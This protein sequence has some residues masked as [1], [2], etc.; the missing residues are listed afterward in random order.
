MVAAILGDRLFGHD[1][2]SFW[3]SMTA[4]I[5]AFVPVPF[6]FA[7]FFLFFFHVMTMLPRDDENTMP[8]KNATIIKTWIAL[9][10]LSKNNIK[11][12]QLYWRSDGGLFKKTFTISTRTASVILIC[13]E[14]AKKC[15]EPKTE[16][17]LRKPISYDLMKHHWGTMLWVIQ[18]HLPI[19]LLCLTEEPNS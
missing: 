8:G 19:H 17:A 15:F 1:D 2:I 12:Q 3:N 5:L 11:T 4:V 13:Q 10:A 16:R 18:D 9:G 14:A 6:P 7:F